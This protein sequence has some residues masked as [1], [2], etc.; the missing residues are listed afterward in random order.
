MTDV[1][2]REICQ[3]RGPKN[4]PESILSAQ[5]YSDTSLRAQT[6]LQWHSERLQRGSESDRK[7]V[8]TQAA[9]VANG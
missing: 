5:G 3:E 1:C 9:E 6:S 7:A 8:L 2:G 4:A